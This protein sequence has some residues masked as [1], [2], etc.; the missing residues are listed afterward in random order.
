MPDDQLDLNFNAEFSSEPLTS[1]EPVILTVSQLNKQI[2][3]QLEGRFQK[4]WLRGEISNFKPHTSGHFYFSLKD[5]GSQISAV[6]FRG[7]NQ[8]L[9]FRPENGLEVIA[10][11]KVTVYEPRGNYQIFCEWIEPVGAGALQKAFEQL[12]AKLEKE[13]LFD[14]GKKRPLPNYP[15][16]VGVVT[17]PTGAAIKDILNVLS[18]R[19]R[20]LQVTVIPTLVQGPGAAEQIAAA[21]KLAN[22]VKDIDVLIVGRGG[23]SAED[24][25]PFNEEVVARA[26]AASGI[27]TI[28]AVGHEV[29]FTIS[30]FVADL[31]APTPSAA[32]ELVVKNV[33]D[34]IEKLTH[35]EKRLVQ[36][37]QVGLR[38]MTDQCR[39]LS[40][41]LVDP[42]RRLQD[43][44][45]R[46]DE[47][48]SRL[49]LAIQR[50]I[51]DLFGRVEM[52]THR[53]PNPMVMI[54]QRRQNLRLMEQAL[55]GET[56]SL[57]N[58][59]MATLRELMAK[60][61]AMSPLKVV[62]RGYSIVTKSSTKKIIKSA[63]D[64]SAGESIEVQFGRGSA[65]AA[66]VK[67]DVKD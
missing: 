2:R 52:A 54:E 65:T 60:L 14:Q 55:R 31:R 49:A 15:K 33:G 37:M 9:K 42:R 45:I 48:S 46:C 4:V 23:G 64:L 27:P 58:N 21:I 47:L 59:R 35:L 39:I 24:L 41:R 62:E 28:S 56:E 67:V 8:K 61:Q 43:L 57:I 30:D 40:G 32:A 10:K 34:L 50:A 12:K 29:D 5:E 38:K 25:W 22:Q 51:S 3:G 53:L 44:I 6:M 63:A 26:I 17:S 16:H 7:F 19:N 1:D 36:S 11:G 13:G 20:G 18:R 66:V